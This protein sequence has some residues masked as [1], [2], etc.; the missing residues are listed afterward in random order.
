MP[1]NVSHFAI[2]A[3]DIDASRSFYE[4]VFGWRFTAFGPPGFFKIQT[5]SDA[6]PGI[7]GALQQRRQL[8]PGAPATGLECTFG[9]ESVDAVAAAV[10]TAGGEILMPR[11][12]ITGVGHLIFF[13]DPAGNAIGAMEYDPAAG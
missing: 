7:L 11:S 5:G 1:A 13:K 10:L 6:E 12:T 4:H 9:V 3:D 2:N 8:V